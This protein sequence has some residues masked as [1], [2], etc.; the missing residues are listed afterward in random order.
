MDLDDSATV[1]NMRTNDAAPTA[2]LRMALDALAA[3]DPAS[4]PACSVRR[5]LRELLTATNRLHA[6]LVRRVAAFDATRSSGDDGCRTTRAWLRVFGRLSHAG[7]TRLVR[8][9]RLLSG[10]PRLADAAAKGAVS[11]EHVYRVDRL[12]EEIGVAAVRPVEAAL[13]EFASWV[14]P[15]VLGRAC[16][17]VRRPGGDGARRDP[18][19]GFDRRGITLSP[20]GGT[21]VVRGQLDPEGAAA[22]RTALDAL[23]R[24]SPGGDDRLPAQ[25]RADA[26]VELARLAMRQGRLP[27]AP[28]PLPQV[29]RRLGPESLIT[30]EDLPAPP[31]D[32]PPAEDSPS[33]GEGL[34]ERDRLGWRGGRGWAGARLDRRPPG[35]PGTTH[36]GPPGP[37]GT[38]SPGA[39]D[40]S[41]TTRSG[42][43]RRLAD[44][45]SGASRTVPWPDRPPTRH[46]PHRA[47]PSAHPHEPG[48]PPADQS[49]ARREAGLDDREP[50]DGWLGRVGEVA[51]EFARRLAC[52][53]DI[54]E[55]MFDPA[56]GWT[57][58]FDGPHRL[59]PDSLR[60]TLHARD[61]GCVFP[62]CDLP[63]EW[64]D[65]HFLKS[66]TNGGRAELGNVVL[67]CRH[68]HG[69]VH[70]GGW[71]ITRETRTGVLEARR[72]DGG[73]FRLF[74]PPPP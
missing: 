19:A 68:H 9:A 1:S 54:R 53:A 10:L 15:T 5:D 64:T 48:E 50:S 14:D 70:E 56:N 22:V 60:Q 28:G 59:V 18:G 27:W 13:A 65:A 31:E 24:I 40:G 7:A 4:L 26:L 69:L 23:T 42:V 58:N 37:P 63:P 49:D 43:L 57:T 73:R 16:A 6:E 25:R 21:V 29:E 11:A 61:A 41:V 34:A 3:Q 52:D 32:A 72:P 44:L 45:A 71:T 36:P 46:T 8:A 2:A 47:Q 51:D 33:H 30:P 12:A 17:R 35:R 38:T 55:V 62:G 67:L 74:D 20:L 39:V 66:W